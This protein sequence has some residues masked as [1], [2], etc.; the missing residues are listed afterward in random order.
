MRCNWASVLCSCDR[1]IS[2]EFAQG[3]LG[4][5]KV[6]EGRSL[7]RSLELSHICVRQLNRVF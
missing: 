1:P 2:I 6:N 5:I 3:V 4:I 7:E